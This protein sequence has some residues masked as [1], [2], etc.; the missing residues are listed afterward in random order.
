MADTDITEEQLNVELAAIKTALRAG[1]YDTARLELG[2]ARATLAALAGS[3]GHDGATTTL[4][5]QSLDKLE[6]TI[7]AIEASAGKHSGES[8]IGYLRMGW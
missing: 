8:R 5:R 3:F 7:D 1:N 2:C 6:T 4:Y